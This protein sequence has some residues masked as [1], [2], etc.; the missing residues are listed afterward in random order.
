M[1]NAINLVHIFPVFYNTADDQRVDYC[2]FVW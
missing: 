2:L 1:R